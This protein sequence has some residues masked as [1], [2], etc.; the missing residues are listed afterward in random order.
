MNGYL[1]LLIIITIIAI[2]SLITIICLTNLKKY[3]EI[4][5]IS[6]ED[7]NKNLD[8]KITI[9][10][11]INNEIKKVVKDKDYLEEYLK[12]KD[13][14][15]SS[16]EKDIKLNEAEELINKLLID[17]EKANNTKVKKYL[18]EL[19]KTNEKLTS[20]KNLFNKHASNNNALIKKFPYNIV[21]KLFN[22]KIKSYYTTNKNED[23]ENF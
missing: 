13:T 9:I 8:T 23:S 3:K 20:S 2:I 11:S 4:I 21:S 1:V 19:R 22:Y 15:V 16:I 10:N 18:G 7:I 14:N 17:Y 12:I 5:T 6:E